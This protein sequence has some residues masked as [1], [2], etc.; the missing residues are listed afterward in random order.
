MLANCLKMMHHRSVIATPHFAFASRMHQKRLYIDKQYVTIPE[1]GL[2]LSLP[3]SGT[4]PASVNIKTYAKRARFT[5][6]PTPI[7]DFI[8]FK[9]MSGNEIILN[10]ENHE[11]MATSELISGLLELGKHDK[12]YRFNWNNHP[13]TALALKDLKT[14]IGHMNAK[15]LLQTAMVLD[16]L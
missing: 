2:H 14:R 8:N 5:N 6:Q 16:R 10:L 7:K 15:N 13:I 9:V 4:R 12:L 1:G 3:G 11:N